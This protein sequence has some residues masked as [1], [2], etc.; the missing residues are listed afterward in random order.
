MRRNPIRQADLALRLFCR[1][2]GRKQRKIVLGILF[3][4]FRPF[5]YLYGR[6]PSDRRQEP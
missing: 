3:V 5:L 6:C 2:L 1:Q 4:P